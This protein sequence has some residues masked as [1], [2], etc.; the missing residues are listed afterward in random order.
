MGS[1][2]LVEQWR[3]FNEPE[4][5]EADLKEWLIENE[6]FLLFPQNRLI[7]ESIASQIWGGI[8][9]KFANAK[10]WTY[11]QYI[12][13]VKP[14]LTRLLTYVNNLK[15]KGFLKKYNTRKIVHGIKLFSTKKYIK[16]GA[17]FLVA[18][19]NLLVGQL[20]NLPK[21]IEM[22]ITV[23]SAV[24]EGKLDVAAAATGL[25]LKEIIILVG[26]LKDFKQDYNKTALPGTDNIGSGDFELAEQ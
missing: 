8:R 25:P 22:L 14:L 21:K 4:N 1:K 19:A 3:Y 20:L 26:S 16:V 12:T 13:L 15:E 2:L 5:S 9:Q 10:E 23:I 17:I 7:S 11:K 24:V 18:M 6:L